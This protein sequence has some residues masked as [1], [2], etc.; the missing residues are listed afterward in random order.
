LFQPHLA[1]S[2]EEYLLINEFLNQKLGLN[3][4]EQKKAIL[5][6]RL[7]SRLFELHLNSFKDY[8]LRLLFKENGELERLSTL[9][10]NNETYFFR[11]AIHFE[12]V[13]FHAL[14]DLKQNASSTK[15]IRI[16][17]AGCSSGEE[18]YTLNIFAVENQ[19]RMWGY[20]LTIDAYDIDKKRVAMALEA[21][22]SPHS[23]RYL[24]ERNIAKYF[25]RNNGHYTLR[26][27]YRR[28]VQFA[29][30]NLL[31]SDTYSRAYLYDVLFCRNVL[32]YFTEQALLKAIQNFARIMRPG[33]LLFLGHSESIIG[34][35]KEFTTVRLGDSIVY[36]KVAT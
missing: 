16:L 32:I 33:G 23:L 15:S 4:P 6:A 11:E 3:F 12:A 20:T 31:E 24:S 22:Y 9:I 21:E 36:K 17:S 30:G 19:Y 7:K 10:T 25:T 2:Q 29:Y 14:E 1:M 26:P 27:M 13:F 28:G 34:L 5:E 8:Y 18:P 35:T